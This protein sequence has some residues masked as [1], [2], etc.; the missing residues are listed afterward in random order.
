METMESLKNCHTCKRQTLMR[1]PLW[2]DCAKCKEDFDLCGK[3]S[4]WITKEEKQSFDIRGITALVNKLQEEKLEREVKKKEEFSA[5][6]DILI[7]N[8]IIEVLKAVP[9]RTNC[10]IN[11]NESGSR[12]II[13]EFLNRGF[14]VKELGTKSGVDGN[15]YC[16]EVSGWKEFKNV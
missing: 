5:F 3:R 10:T 16:I 14:I 2:G 15:Y 4:R 13:S 11:F 1:L 12:E 9:D 8:N 7:K 6:C